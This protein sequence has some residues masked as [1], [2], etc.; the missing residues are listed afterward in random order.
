MSPFESY[1]PEFQLSRSV[2]VRIEQNTRQVQR[3]AHMASQMGRPSGD[4][5]ERALEDARHGKWGAFQSKRG[6][7]LMAYLLLDLEPVTKTSEYLHQLCVVLDRHKT[8][9]IETTLLMATMAH[10]SEPHRARLQRL[11]KQHVPEKVVPT[12]VRSLRPYLVDDR[13]VANL[14]QWLGGLPVRQ[15]SQQIQEM[16]F[17]PGSGG[18]GFS[19][20]CSKA[21]LWKKW[22]G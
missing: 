7:R 21:H 9:S 20:M 6:A 10:W 18:Q 4:A 15:W 13:G 12:G 2:M 16:G 22:P 14:A 3:V 17:T 11:V 8:K 1:K 19:S 5:L